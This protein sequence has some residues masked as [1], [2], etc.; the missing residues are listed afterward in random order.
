MQSGTASGTTVMKGGYDAVQL[1]GV[2]IGDVASSGGAI[3][4]LSGG[5]DQR[6]GDL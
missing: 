1:G 6:G 5:G 4:A 3:Y 2:I